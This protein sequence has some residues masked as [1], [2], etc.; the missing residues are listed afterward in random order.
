M[1]EESILT[2]LEVASIL[3]ISKNTVYEMVK[4]GEI[5]SFRVGNKVRIAMKDVEEYKN[6]TMRFQNNKN[7]N[8]NSI[9]VKDNIDEPQYKM[10]EQQKSNNFV[11]C[12]QDIMLDIL[13]RHLQ[14]HPKGVV[15]L[16]SYT[17]SYD[18]LYEL[19][20]GRVQ[21][22]TVHLWDGETGE[23]N[24]PYVKRMLPGVKSVIIHL[25]TRM[26]GFYVAKENPKGI[27]DWEDLN[28]TDI[29]IIN[30]EKGSG[31]RILLDEQIKKLGISSSNISGYE[32]EATSH[33]AVASAVARGGADLGV[34]N[35]KASQQVSGVEFIPL[36]KERYD[37][38]IKKEDMM[39]PHFQTVLQIL[40]SEEF[41]LELQG[42]GGYDLENLG[43]IVAET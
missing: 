16:R 24:V 21:L 10:Q 34:G 3:K 20:H 43:D 12:G 15:A 17:G 11:I 27:R 22:A 37:L 33:L 4:R 32:R 40:K 5:N 25:A 7:S 39:K 28:R 14:H 35:E 38:V 8:E 31:S 26:Q 2:P 36:Q 30:R 29:S 6:R 9:R 19:Y 42:I 18:G 1:G 41:K 13:S 23:Y